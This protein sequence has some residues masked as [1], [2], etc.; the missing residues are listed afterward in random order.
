MIPRT[1]RLGDDEVARG[2]EDGDGDREA[3][4]EREDAEAE[5][6]VHEVSLRERTRVSGA[7]GNMSAQ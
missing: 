3:E 1:S 5:G 7:S 4:R 2:V 6:E